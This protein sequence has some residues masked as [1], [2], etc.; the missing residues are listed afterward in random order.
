MFQ[1]IS[2]VDD[3]NTIIQDLKSRGLLKSDDISDGFHNFG[4]LY[5]HRAILFASLCN[6]H[7]DMAFKSKKHSDGTM[8]EGMFIVGLLLPEGQAT[9]HYDLVPYWDLFDVPEL[10][11]APVFDGHTPAMAIER[12]NNFFN[13]SRDKNTGI[14][15]NTAL[16]ELNRGRGI[17]LASWSSD[18]LIRSIPDGDGQ[19]MVS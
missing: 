15:Y 13:S 4:E 9:Y 17:R 16:E 3:L 6:Q 1:N 14:S 7:R 10:D 12:I 18:R 8:F 5:H 19:S 2:S 11:S